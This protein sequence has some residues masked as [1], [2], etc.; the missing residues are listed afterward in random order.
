MRVELTMEH[1][2]ADEEQP[3]GVQRGD[4]RFL[5]GAHGALVG[6]KQCRAFF[7]RFQWI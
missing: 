1:G 7:D 2:H 5:V 6:A 4:Q 3:E